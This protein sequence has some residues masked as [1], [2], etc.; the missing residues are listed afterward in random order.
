MHIE[1]LLM[2][3]GFEMNNKRKGFESSHI[4][5]VRFCY[6]VIECVMKPLCSILASQIPKRSNS[7]YG[8]I[9]P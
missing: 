8:H 4:S 1:P 3:Q 5:G 9:Q 2:I 6:C 7:S